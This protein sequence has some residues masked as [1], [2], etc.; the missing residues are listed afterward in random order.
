MKLIRMH[1]DYLH[2]WP[3]QIGFFIA[4][5]KGWYRAAGWDVDLISDGWER[6]TAGE[7]VARGEY[8]IGLVRLGELL[9]T[10]HKEHP[11]LGCAVLN[12]RALEGLITLKSKGINRFKDLEG[13]T[14][15]M[16]TTHPGYDQGSVILETELENYPTVPRMLEMFKQAVEADGGDF[17]KVK[18]VQTHLWEADIR[19]IEKGYVDAIASVPGWESEQGVAPEEEVV[20]MRFDDVGVAPHHSYFI[21]FE[22][23]YA[24]NNPDFVKKFLQI[25]ARGFKYAYENPERAIKEY[26]TVMWNVDPAVI[27]RSLKYMSRSWFDKSGKWGAINYDLVKSYAQWMIDGDFT[28]ASLD[29]IALTI[30]DQMLPDV[31][32]ETK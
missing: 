21:S 11:L 3:N 28:T 17:S 25:S 1:L 16:P 32:I 31:F 15:A 8:H 10:S 23:E 26:G 22:K 29:D 14:V 4:R 13:R 30:T 27:A 5:Y 7:K 24:R 19:A 20:R 2:P 12:Q 9:E 6:G 18:I